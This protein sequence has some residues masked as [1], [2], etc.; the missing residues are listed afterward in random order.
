MPEVFYTLDHLDE[1]KPAQDASL[2][3]HLCGFAHF[4]VKMKRPTAA[5]G[6]TQR[7]GDTVGPITDG[8]GGGVLPPASESKPD[9][10][11]PSA[12]PALAF[13]TP[14]PPGPGPAVTSPVN[15]AFR[16]GA[17]PVGQPTLLRYDF[18]A[19][20]TTKERRPEGRRLTPLACYAAR[21]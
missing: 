14:G 8:G 9:R 20:A 18:A 2:Y 4:R 15:L 6:T 12:A 16:S 10:A 1:R 13:A 5:P 7:A 21:A 3:Y 17:V 11:S 19:W